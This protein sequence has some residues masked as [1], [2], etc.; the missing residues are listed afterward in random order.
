ME[1]TQSGEDGIESEDVSNEPAIRSIFDAALEFLRLVGSGVFGMKFFSSKRVNSNPAHHMWG[2]CG[3][4]AVPGVGHLP[5]KI[6]TCRYFQQ[7][8]EPPRCSC[9]TV[10]AFAIP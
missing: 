6:S 4:F 1:I 2:I 10:G 9:S 3:V 8:D 5:A 7:E